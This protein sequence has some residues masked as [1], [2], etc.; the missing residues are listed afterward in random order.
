VSTALVHFVGAA[1][2]RVDLLIG[3]YQAPFIWGLEE[4]MSLPYAGVNI[5]R[6]S[7]EETVEAFFDRVGED[8]L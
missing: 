6:K 2:G 5:V 3:D 1:G 4:G 8:V 7:K